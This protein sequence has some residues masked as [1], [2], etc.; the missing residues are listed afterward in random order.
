MTDDN[1]NWKY[2]PEP[3]RLTITLPRVAWMTLDAILE[4]PD[5]CDT[6]EELVAGFLQIPVEGLTRPATW[7]RGWLESYFGRER[8]AAAQRAFEQDC[9][10]FEETSK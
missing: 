3:R 8:V 1:F 9:Q 7:Q 2:Q 4:Q 5:G 10:E 6:L